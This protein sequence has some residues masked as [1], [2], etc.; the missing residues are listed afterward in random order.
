MKTLYGFLAIAASASSGEV[1]K[2]YYWLRLGL[3]C[4]LFVILYSWNCSLDR[5]SL[6][7]SL[8]II[9]IIMII[10]L[11]LHTSHTIDPILQ[12]II[13]VHGGGFYLDG[14]MHAASSGFLRFLLFMFFVDIVV[15][16]GVA[17]IQGILFFRCSH[18]VWA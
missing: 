15:D 9:W 4:I 14:L 5:F 10:I 7:P 3:E 17:V 11:H 13:F 2:I 6:I 1:S 12:F 18:V 16:A 8:F